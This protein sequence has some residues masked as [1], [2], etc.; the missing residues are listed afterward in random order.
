MEL[1]RHAPA[2]L[3]EPLFLRTA[4]SLRGPAT[5]TAKGRPRCRG[6]ARRRAY[7]RY[8]ARPQ[9]SACGPLRRLGLVEGQ[10]SKGASMRPQTPRPLAAVLPR[11]RRR[12]A[13]RKRLRRRTDAA[14]LSGLAETESGV[15]GRARSPG[16]RARR[17]PPG[18]RRAAAW[19]AAAPW[20]R[21]AQ[22]AGP[23]S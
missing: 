3:E 9:A 8:L 4:G 22:L 20:S 14:L 16:K 18:P 19:D 1:R 6:R 11:S 12:V 17:A 7:A 21:T 2:R 13:A 5:A 10:T 23:C 15:R